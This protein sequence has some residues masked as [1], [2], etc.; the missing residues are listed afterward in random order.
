VTDAVDGTVCTVDAAGRRLVNRVEVEPGLGVI[1]FTPDGRLGFFV[2]P[3]RNQ[4]YVIDPSTNR[5]V[6]RAKVAEGPDRVTFSS[7]FAYIRHRGS[8]DVLMISLESAGREGAELSLN[9]FPAGQ[10]P[11][12]AMPDPPPADSIVPAPGAG[13]VLVA[14]PKDQ[15]VYYYR[16]GLAAPMGTFTNYKREP[17]A[18]LVIDRSL[19][20][21]SRPG[22][23]ETVAR[24]DRPGRFDLL[25]LL[26]QPRI[27]HAFQVVV[28]PDPDRE[29]E[30]N[31]RK[32]D[33]Q[34]LVALTRLDSGA[35]FRPLLE[36]TGHADGAPKAGLRDVE[37]LMYRVGGGWQARRAGREIAAGVY[38]ADFTPGPPGVYHVLV[39]CDSIDLP[40]NNP[41]RLTLEVT[42]PTETRPLAGSGRASGVSAAQT[43]PGNP[44]Q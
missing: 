24:L 22:V 4:V 6:Q 14:N 1:R 27:I 12:G 2:N 35:S 30:R 38:G 36:L 9:R 40:L 33:V 26:D 19:R 18:V 43:S 31:R 11:P 39:T 8:I 25:F 3:E 21:R 28:E 37:L 42:D 34:P 29:L 32:V 15:S 17:R 16:E 41:H 20:E 13:A 7:E 23:Y 44:V 10:S 5:V